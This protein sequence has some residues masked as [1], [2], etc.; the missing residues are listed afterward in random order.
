M[1]MNLLVLLLAV[2]GMAAVFMAR[3]GDYRQLASRDQQTPTRVFA[4]T[5]VRWR[6]I[7]GTLT[8]TPAAMTS[9]EHQ[10]QAPKGKMA[11]GHIP[12]VF[13]TSSCAASSTIQRT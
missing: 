8:G 5:G 4:G 9:F 12:V 2:V 3:T 13:A 6:G 10:A 1:Q 11:T 7:A